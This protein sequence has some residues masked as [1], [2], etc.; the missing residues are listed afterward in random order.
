LTIIRHGDGDSRYENIFVQCDVD[1]G[2]A[3]EKDMGDGYMFDKPGRYTVTIT[4]KSN[5]ELSISF[6]LQVIG[7]D[8]TGTY[9]W[10]S[11]T[12]AKYHVDPGCSNMQ[13]VTA[14]TVAEAE[15]AGY[16]PC[17]VCHGE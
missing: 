9:V 11:R 4:D 7:V 12:G 3:I 5:P 1:F 14:M 10:V 13:S 6:T 8:P 16:E 17:K 2:G 15:A